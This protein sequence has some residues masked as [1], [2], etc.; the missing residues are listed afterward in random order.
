MKERKN[1]V[2]ELLVLI[3]LNSSFH[4]EAKTEAVR[5]LVLISH[6]SETISENNRSSSVLCPLILLHEQI[7]IV[8]LIKYCVQLS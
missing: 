6:T 8:P 4:K 1:G 2:V 7:G 5:R 3:F